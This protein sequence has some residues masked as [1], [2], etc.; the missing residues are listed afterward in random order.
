M[1]RRIARLPAAESL[2][3]FETATGRGCRRCF[4]TDAPGVVLASS[5]RDCPLT[6]S[7]QS[8]QRNPYERAR[9]SGRQLALALHRRDA[10]FPGLPMVAEIAREFEAYGRFR[11]SAKQRHDRNHLTPP[12]S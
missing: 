11:G 6:G 4:D 2:D 1:V 10:I 5:P 8:G 12:R 7:P 3:L 9:P